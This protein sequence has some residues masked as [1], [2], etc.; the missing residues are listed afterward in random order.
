[1]GDFLDEFFRDAAAPLLSVNPVVG[2]STPFITTTSSGRPNCRLCHLVLG[3]V[4]R[5]CA[6]KGHQE[7]LQEMRVNLSRAL[8]DIQ[9]VSATRSAILASEIAMLNEGDAHG[10]MPFLLNC[11]DSRWRLLP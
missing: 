4:A 11:Y 6:S 10:K 8:F 3:N 5:H 7:K 1:M 9:R 2:A